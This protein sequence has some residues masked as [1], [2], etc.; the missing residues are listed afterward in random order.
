MNNL[1]LPEAIDVLRKSLEEDPDYFQGWQSNIAMSFYDEYSKND[2]S[3]K[4]KED[5]HNIS[6]E[7]AKN[8][9]NLLLNE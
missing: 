5:L 7:A 1:L 4:N 6:N 9:L 3:Y 8:F 2:K